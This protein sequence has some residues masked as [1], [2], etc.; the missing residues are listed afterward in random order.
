MRGSR[1]MP[2][3]PFENRNTESPKNGG[4]EVHF[5]TTI[6][7]IGRNEL[8]SSIHSVNEYAVANE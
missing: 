6:S 4:V 3:E 7:V 1:L 2:R 5:V 8:D